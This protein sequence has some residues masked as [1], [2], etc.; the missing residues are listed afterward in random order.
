[1]VPEGWVQR[2]LD[3]AERSPFVP[4]VAATAEAVRRRWTSSTPSRRRLVLAVGAA[5]VTVGVVVAVVPAGA[6]QRASGMT[7]PGGS[8]GT[9]AGAPTSVPGATASA[10]ADPALTA[11]DVLAA[12]RALVTARDRCLASLSVLCLDQVDEARSG[13]LDADQAAIR[14]AQQGGELPDALGGAVISDGPPVLIE[15]LGDSALVRLGATASGAS[16]LLVKGA[17]GWRI[18]DV[19]SAGASRGEVGG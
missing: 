11:N 12:T 19:F 16:L 10:A 4:V 5:A 13:A 2:V 14:G 6:G 3:T 7:G 9:W 1:V 17:A 18:R 15:R 8:G